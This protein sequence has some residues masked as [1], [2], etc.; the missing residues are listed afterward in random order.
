M[1]IL[2]RYFLAMIQHDQ[3]GIVFLPFDGMH[4]RQA[5]IDIRAMLHQTFHDGD[6]LIPFIGIP[7][8]FFSYG[9]SSFLAF[10]LLLFVF[11]RQDADRNALI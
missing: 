4:N 2:I 3:G 8:P 5:D 9:G 7:L 10:T 6:P 1:L 11:I